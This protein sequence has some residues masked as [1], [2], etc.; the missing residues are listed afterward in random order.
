MEG[1]TPKHL[2]AVESEFKAIACRDFQPWCRKS[3]AAIVLVL[4]L[5]SFILPQQSGMAV[6][7][8][9]QLAQML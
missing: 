7:I 4:G 2:E 3:L 1:N 8:R 5:L 9:V 6:E